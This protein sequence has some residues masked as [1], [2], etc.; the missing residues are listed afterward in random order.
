MKNHFKDFSIFKKLV[1]AFSIIIFIGIIVAV[2]GMIGMIGMIEIN[3]N[4][5][6]HYE[7]ETA[8]IEHLINAIK[9]CMRSV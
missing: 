3:K 2:I 6:Q 7:Q 5:T 9:A 4:D 1:T 8:P